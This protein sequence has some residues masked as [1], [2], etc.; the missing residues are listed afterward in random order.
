MRS[1]RAHPMAREAEGY[2]AI[3]ESTTDIC[4]VSSRRGQDIRTEI[5]QDGARRLLAEAVRA[6]VD[7]H[8]DL[9]GGVLLGHPGRLV[10]LRPTKDTLPPQLTA[11]K[12][13]ARGLSPLGTKIQ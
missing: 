12:K 5:L 4:L 7:A 8:A 13:V 2:P 10:V 1:L 3:S 11:H 9:R 6:E